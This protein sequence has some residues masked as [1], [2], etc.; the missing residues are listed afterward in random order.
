MAIISVEEDFGSRSGSIDQ[1]FVHKANRKFLVFS[2]SPSDT[3]LTVLANAS[4]PTAFAN[5]PGSTIVKV[6]DRKADQ[7]QGSYNPWKWTVD[8]QYTSKFDFDTETA[9]ENP[10]SRPAIWKFTWE[11]AE[12]A[13]REDLDGE[14]IVNSAGSPIN[15]PLTTTYGVQVITIEVNK[16]ALDPVVLLD[17][18]DCTNNAEWYGFPANTVLIRGLSAEPA[19]ENG[20]AYWKYTWTLAVKSLLYDGWRPTQIL[21]CGFHEYD[22]GTDSLKLI[23]DYA[24]HPLS[25]PTLL[26]DGLKLPSGEEPEYLSYNLTR[27]ADFSTLIG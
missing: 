21:D 25:E 26:R 9:N 5:F 2:D 15:P 20:T 3:Y 27:Q 12:R 8:V 22:E 16:A 23:T 24:G 4:I 6:S 7:V 17:L 1:K 13:V 14:Q 18:Q 19:T 11:K 10:L